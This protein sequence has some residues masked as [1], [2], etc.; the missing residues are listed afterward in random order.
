MP[1]CISPTPT[2]G[3]INLP[4]QTRKEE[5][6]YW[7]ST[8]YMSI[9]SFYINEKRWIEISKEREEDSIHTQTTSIDPQSVLISLR[10]PE[11]GM[12]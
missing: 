9:A 6:S 7:C 3:D 8:I 4:G 5:K 10:Y 1:Q 11:E 2:T 12:A